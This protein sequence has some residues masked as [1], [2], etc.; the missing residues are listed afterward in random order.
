M[1]AKVE[2]ATVMNFVPTQDQAHLNPFLFHILI[3]KNF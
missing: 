1:L 3:K 2:T